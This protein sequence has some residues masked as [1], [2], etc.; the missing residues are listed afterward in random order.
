MTSDRHAGGEFGVDA[1]HQRLVG[2]PPRPRPD[3]GLART[4]HPRPGRSTGV[5]AGQHSS[6]VGN[7][8]IVSLER[9][10]KRSVTGGIDV[11][12]GDGLTG[13]KHRCFVGVHLHDVPHQIQRGPTRAGRNPR[14]ESAAPQR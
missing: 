6:K 4:L 13:S 8:R 7:H 11:S 14:I 2:H 9:L 5:E 1:M 3:R 12:A 10:G